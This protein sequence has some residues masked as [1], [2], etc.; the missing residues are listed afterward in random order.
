MKNRG[1][2]NDNE[3]TGLLS[4]PQVLTKTYA[5]SVI[6]IY[7]DGEITDPD[8]Y[9]EAY[10]ALSNAAPQDIIF[11]HINSVGGR[12]DAGIQII[13]HINRCE[14]RVVGVLHMECASMASAIALA[15][16]DWELNTFS[17]MMIHSCSYGAVGKQSDILSRVEF[18]TKFNE[19]FIRETY[20]G[21]LSEEEIK[22]VL[23][24]DDLYFGSKQIDKR[25][26]A[27]VE[28][29]SNH[30]EEEVEEILPDEKPIPVRKPR[31]KKEAV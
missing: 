18:S 21:F 29:R 20:S 3:L 1:A 9:R 26:E 19:E 28:Y 2:K 27:F 4:A 16:D 23:R 25:L 24:G 15:C 22:A 7:L 13:N 17:T 31:V 14:A 10:H 6:D 30:E 5:N 8:R 11:L 12:L